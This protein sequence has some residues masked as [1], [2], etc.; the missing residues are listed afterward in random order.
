MNHRNISAIFILIAL[1]AAPAHAEKIVPDNA[2]H[3]CQTDADCVLA[4]AVCGPIAVNRNYQSIVVE[5]RKQ[6]DK[7]SDC[8]NGLLYAKPNAVACKF[9]SCTAVFN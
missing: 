6:Q 5:Y 8:K 3:A 7:K 1:S 2:W 9:E 4:E